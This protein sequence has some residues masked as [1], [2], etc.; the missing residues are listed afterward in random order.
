MFPVVGQSM[1]PTAQS[2]LIGTEPAS[3]NPAFLRLKTLEK[4]KEPLHTIIRFSVKDVSALS[5]SAEEAP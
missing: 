1:L 4:L 5:S 2:L 3:R